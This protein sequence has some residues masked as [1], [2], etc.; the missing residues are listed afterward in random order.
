[1]GI[2]N[3]N[4]ELANMDFQWWNPTRIIFGD[5]KVSELADDLELDWNFNG[6]NKAIVVTDEGVKNAGLLDYL[7]D[8]LKGTDREVIA[9]FDHVLEEAD[10][11]Q[12][13]EI[14]KLAK[15]TNP[16]F[17]IALGGG[18]VMDACKAAAVLESN[19]GE[20]E[21]FEGL[22]LVDN[23]SKPIIC[24]PTTAGTG[25]EV[26]WGAVIMNQQEKKKL[27]MG[28]YKFIPKL[29]VLDPEMTKTLPPHLVAA[30][31][32]DAL[33]HAIGAVASNDRQDISSALAL[34]CIEMV[35]DNL[36]TAYRDNANDLDTRSKMLI[37]STLGGIAFQTA[38]PGAD[39][40]IGHSAG[41][42][43]HIHHGIA[44]GICNLYVM[45]FNMSAIPH[46]Y[47]SIARALGVKDNGES[48]ESLGR[49]G[50]ERLQELYQ[51]VDIKLT[52]KDYG[53]P[54][55]TDMVETLAEHSLDDA[56][57]AFNPVGVERCPEFDQLIKN[58]IG[59]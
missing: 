24:I 42:L 11:N 57:M 49:K 37:A 4:V 59:V 41:A 56:C 35:A 5:G 46:H 48:D 47:A 13:Y 25:S 12:V 20:L 44:V 53:F 32:L 51:K 7:L 39:H 14:A 30:T 58:C 21:D 9:I 27:I 6:K 26:T 54:S 3:R 55:D 22:H 40:G 10:R 34:R 43:H 18:S 52:L 19:E 28:D 23:E 29:A 16:D 36:E 2:F 17:W 38:L 31:G 15:Q 50:I 1:M 8:S 45:E 33:T